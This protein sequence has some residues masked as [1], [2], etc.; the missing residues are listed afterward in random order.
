VVENIMTDLD[1]PL[2]PE[3]W[4]CYRSLWG[5][6]YAGRTLTGPTR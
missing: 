5:T 3:T 1:S 2:R 6:E 4:R